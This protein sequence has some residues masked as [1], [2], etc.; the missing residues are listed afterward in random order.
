[1]HVLHHPSRHLALTA[2]LAFALALLFILAGEMLSQVDLN[3][4]SGGGAATE[5]TTV[6]PA[7]WVTDPM[8]PPTILLTR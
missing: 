2:L 5:P 6:P 4:F 3:L 8:A 1:M 7:H